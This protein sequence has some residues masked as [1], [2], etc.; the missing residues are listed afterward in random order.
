MVKKICFDMDG[1]I[2]D[3]YHVNDW[4]NKIN[5]KDISP[6]IDAK[7]MYNM[8]ILNS[9]L[10]ALRSLG[11]VI[12]VITWL[13]KT[14]TPEYN[15]EV[16]KAKKEWLTKNNFPCDEFHAVKYGTPKHRVSKGE[17]QI[18]VDDNTSV[19]KAWTKGDVI[20]AKENIIPALCALISHEV[21]CNE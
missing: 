12:A 7:P 10:N 5:N 18:L 20:N 11:Y 17:W 2:A 16:R 8:D 14:G 3:L 21:M 15:K 1:T 19:Q 13:S 6:Y 4:C 9:L